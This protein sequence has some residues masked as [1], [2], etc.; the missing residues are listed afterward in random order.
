MKKVLPVVTLIAAIGFSSIAQAQPDVYA[1]N[2]KAAQGASKI[3]AHSNPTA[4]QVYATKSQT[5][6]NRIYAAPS[7]TSKQT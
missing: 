7:S 1:S 2:A 4:P 3:Y 5:K 6:S